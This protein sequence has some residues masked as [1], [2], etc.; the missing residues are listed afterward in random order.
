VL[1]LDQ[2]SWDGLSSLASTAESEDLVDILER[3]IRGDTLSRLPQSAFGS[4]SALMVGLERTAMPFRFFDLPAEV[5]VCIYEIALLSKGRI[6]ALWSYPKPRIE[7]HPRQ[8]EASTQLRQ[9][10]MPVYYSN[11]FVDLHSPFGHHFDK[12][13]KEPGTVDV[14][15]H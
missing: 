10:A 8:L 13:L 4:I 2:S 5:R 12:C 7:P 15:A 11:H 1:Q 9:E 3:Y 14:L 6:H